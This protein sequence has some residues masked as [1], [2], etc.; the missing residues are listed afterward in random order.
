MAEVCRAVHDLATPAAPGPRH[1]RPPVRAV[2]VGQP[3][4]L[5]GA[6]APVRQ[7]RDN[8][9]LVVVVVA[10]PRDEGA[11][12]A[13][14]LGGGQLP[15]PIRSEHRS[16]GAENG[17]IPAHLVGDGGVPRAVEVDDAHWPA[18]HVSEAEQGRSAHRGHRGEH[19]QPVWL[20]AVV[21][22]HQKVLI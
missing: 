19:V 22:K 11:V 6:A 1:A 2:H 21:I 12:R 7:R 8:G 18:G 17:P 10:V 14:R 9:A 5:R 15:Q 20:V 4:P 13:L 3:R 16:P